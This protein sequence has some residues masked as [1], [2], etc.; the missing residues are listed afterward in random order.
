[1][2]L[3]PRSVPND[4]HPADIKQAEQIISSASQRRGCTLQ[5]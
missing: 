5:S 2:K 4:L 1:L 3:D